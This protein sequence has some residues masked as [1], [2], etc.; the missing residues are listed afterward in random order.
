MNSTA[1]VL[2]SLMFLAIPPNYSNKAAKSP[3]RKVEREYSAL[4]YKAKTST[5]F[6]KNR[7]TPKTSLTFSRVFSCYQI[8]AGQIAVVCCC[9]E[10]RPKVDFFTSIRHHNAIKASFRIRELCSHTQAHA[11]DS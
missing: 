7:F 6:K 2:R 8:Q 9:S 3:S 10:E 1:Q 4:L 5:G 11:H